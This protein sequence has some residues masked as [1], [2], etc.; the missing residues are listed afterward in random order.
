MNVKAV[1]LTGS[2][3]LCA[4]AANAAFVEYT[5]VLASNP[6]P[7]SST[8]SL[9]LFDSSLGTLSGV[10]FSLASNIVGR[11]DVFNNTS[12]AQNLTNAFAAIP[13]TVTSGLPDATSVTVAATAVLASGTAA[14]GFV[15]SSFPGIAASASNSAAVLPANFASYTGLGG[16]T[17]LF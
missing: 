1:V 15:V 6:T 14:G 4:S 16:S 8:F 11:V 12:R 17:A 5:A 2:L 13:I 10:T 3:V 9:P 7:F